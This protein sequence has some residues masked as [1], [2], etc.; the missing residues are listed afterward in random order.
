M[1]VAGPVADDPTPTS[2]LMPHEHDESPEIASGARSKVMRQAQ[3]DVAE[4][5]VDTEARTTAVRHFERAQRQTPAH[6]VRAR[7][8]RKE[9]T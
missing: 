5:R 8:G 4:G 1:P 6:A 7:R 9:P 3:R 2:P